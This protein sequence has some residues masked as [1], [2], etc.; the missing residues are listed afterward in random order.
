MMDVA[1]LQHVARIM[2]DSSP[3]FRDAI[4]Q[5][6]LLLGSPMPKDER[7]RLVQQLTDRL[8]ERLSEPDGELRLAPATVEEI[9][10]AIIVGSAELAMTFPTSWGRA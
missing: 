6:A 10:G 8:R 1:R 7:E 9:V 4:T 5:T 3:D 2:S